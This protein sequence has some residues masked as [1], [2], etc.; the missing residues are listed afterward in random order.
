MTPSAGKDVGP[1]TI[2]E[3]KLGFAH[4]GEL[5]AQLNVQPLPKGGGGGAHLCMTSKDGLEYDLYEVL[6]KL[7][8]K[9]RTLPNMVDT[10]RT[11]E[12]TTDEGIRR[13]AKIDELDVKSERLVVQL[14][15][16]LM[17]AEGNAVGSHR[18]EQGDYGWSAAYEAV[19]S[20]Q[21][22]YQEVRQ[23][24]ERRTA[25][26]AAVKVAIENRLDLSRDA[27]RQGAL[28]VLA[29]LDSPSGDARLAAWTL[30][31][32]DDN[33]FVMVELQ[34]LKRDHICPKCEKADGDLDYSCCNEECDGS[35]VSGCYH[36][37][38]AMCMDWALACKLLLHR[39]AKQGE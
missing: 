35:W 6:L 16:C 17:A 1:V 28:V 34:R 11:L 22:C 2:R 20:L 29:A 15:G 25:A 23:E 14:A 7:L 24:L 8:E 31:R 5:A 27:M 12:Q 19:V 18:A 26:D 37:D 3:V 4:L 13:Q 39:R 33:W 32:E 10:V 30:L 38:S 9:V 36:C 21:G